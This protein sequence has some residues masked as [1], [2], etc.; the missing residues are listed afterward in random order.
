MSEVVKVPFFGTKLN[1]L[2]VLIILPVAPDDEPVISSPL[3]NVPVVFV[4][5]SVGATASVVDSES[6]TAAKLNT[7]ALPREMVL[8]VDLIPKAPSS[9]VNKTFSCFINFVVLIF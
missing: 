2:V 8:S 1:G 6:K 9:S 7:S 3:V 4:T 5:V